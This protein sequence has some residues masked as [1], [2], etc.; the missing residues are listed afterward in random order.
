[1]LADQG[2]G[3]TIDDREFGSGPVHRVLTSPEEINE[4]FVQT[5][6]PELAEQALS[7]L[8]NI[9]GFQSFHVSIEQLSHLMNILSS[10]VTEN[11]VRKTLSLLREL[12]EFRSPQIMNFLCQNESIMVIYSFFPNPVSARIL[13]RC[14]EY[15]GDVRAY[16][17]QK[18]AS[19]P[20][21]F[22]KLLTTTD[23]DKLEQIVVCMSSLFSMCE[24]SEVMLVYL[25]KAVEMLCRTNRD[26][27][28]SLSFEVLK[29]LVDKLIPSHPSVVVEVI[30]PA[31]EMILQACGANEDLYFLLMELMQC[32]AKVTGKYEFMAVP[33][34]SAFVI[35]SLRAEHR[36]NDWENMVFASRMLTVADDISAMLIPQNSD[37]VPMFLAYYSMETKIVEK[38]TCVMFLGRCLVYQGNQQIKEL[39][40]VIT[41]PMLIEWITMTD[42]GEDQDEALEFVLVRAFMK[43]FECCTAY[44]LDYDDLFFSETMD[45]FL[46][47]LSSAQAPLGTCACQLMEQITKDT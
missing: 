1:M 21:S 32:V 22:E 5:A 33:S 45:Q 17:L 15:S 27:E 11:M 24:P 20:V 14:V 23:P 19:D 37:L 29:G 39:L 38:K 13:S 31:L 42:A 28:D 46:G 9:C 47:A 16:L 7:K 41:I 35:G 3:A 25:R 43:I 34:I 36:P 4:L 30:A 10:R 6:N 8:L 18:F 2:P 44:N 26:S 12:S 40:T